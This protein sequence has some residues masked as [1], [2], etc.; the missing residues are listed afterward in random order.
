MGYNFLHYG[1][2]QDFL[3]PPDARD[4]LPAGHLSWAV[5]DAVGELDLSEFLA[6]YRSDGQGRPAYHPKMMTALVLYCYCKGI[7]SSRAVPTVPAAE[8]II[9]ALPA[10]TMTITEAEDHARA[11]SAQAA[12]WQ[13]AR[14]TRSKDARR[15]A[16]TRNHPR[17]LLVEAKGIHK[18]AGGSRSQTALHTQWLR[19]SLDQPTPEEIHAIRLAWKDAAA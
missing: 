3:L 6:V 13:N 2:D 4:W 16:L 11:P 19:D 18:V 10:E 12:P 8:R 1:C 14:S 7:R 17:N 5:I 9:Q 15:D